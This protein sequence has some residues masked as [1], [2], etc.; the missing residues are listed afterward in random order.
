M[1]FKHIDII[2]IDGIDMKVNMGTEEKISKIQAITNII[3][4]LKQQPPSTKT[5]N[6]IQLLQQQI[7]EITKS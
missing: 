4:D 2:T 1:K 3:I 7:D 5:K 6:T